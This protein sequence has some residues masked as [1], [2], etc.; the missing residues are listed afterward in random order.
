MVQGRDSS[1]AEGLG[2]VPRRWVGLPPGGPARGAARV[3]AA[4]GDRHQHRGSHDG[5]GRGQPASNCLSTRRAFNSRGCLNRFPSMDMTQTPSMSDSLTGPIEVHTRS[6]DRSWLIT[7]TSPDSNRTWP[8]AG[9]AWGSRSSRAAAPPK[10]LPSSPPHPLPTG[11]N[12]QSAPSLPSRLVTVLTCG[13][14]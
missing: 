1:R 14:R 8:N 12:R 9:S 6:C 5:S 13:Q 3:A 2:A 7:A 11:S 4:T 10:P